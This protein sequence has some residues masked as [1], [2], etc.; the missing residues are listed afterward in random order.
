V[1]EITTS[2]NSAQRWITYCA[3]REIAETAFYTYD[4]AMPGAT[5]TSIMDYSENEPDPCM[6]LPEGILV[7][8]TRFFIDRVVTPWGVWR[9]LYCRENVEATGEEREELEL[10]ILECNRDIL[11]IG[12]PDPRHVEFEIQAERRSKNELRT[13]HD[14]QIGYRITRWEDCLFDSEYESE[15]SS[16]SKKAKRDLLQEWRIFTTDYEKGP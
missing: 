8:T 1:P 16:L 13:L 5:I 9:F 10:S 14:F 3:L 7:T 15:H 4:H 11:A 2:H 12:T 6:R